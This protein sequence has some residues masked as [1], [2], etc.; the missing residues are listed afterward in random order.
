MSGRSSDVHPL[1]SII[2]PTYNRAHFLDAAIDSVEAQGYDNYELLISDDGSTDSSKEVIAKRA[3]VNDKIVYFKN[4]HR[5]GISGARNSALERARGELIAFHDSDDIWAE[6]HLKRAVKALSDFPEVG[7]YF[8]NTQSV[9]HKTGQLLYDL[10]QTLKPLDRIPARKIG[11]DLYYIVDLPLRDAIPMNLIP[12]LPTVVRRKTLGEIRFDTGL[13][14]AE[15]RDFFLRI[16]AIKS[17][18][19]LMRTTPCGYLMR[20]DENISY[21]GDVDARNSQ[22][23]LTYAYAHLRMFESLLREVRLSEVDAALVRDEI[24]SIYAELPYHLRKV[25]RYRDALHT[26]YVNLTRV[27]VKT[28]CREFAKTIGQW[29]LSPLLYLSAAKQTNQ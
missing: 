5:Y 23:R 9:S 27:N 2:T 11:A 4:N 26:C 8:G 3:A 13:E 29:A 19:I 17:P 15:D 14:V 6:D 28:A 7:L 18:R 10:F 24:A 25:H 12:I 22:T 20:H 1:I 16:A 21:I